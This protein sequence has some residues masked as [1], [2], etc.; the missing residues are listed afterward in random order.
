[1]S[2]RGAKRKPVLELR[3]S[4]LDLIEAYGRAEGNVDYRGELTRIR[5]F[6]GRW[7]HLEYWSPRHP[8][9]VDRG[10][11]QPTTYVLIIKFDGAKVLHIGWDGDR[12]NLIT[13]ELGGWE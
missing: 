11:R 8:T 13:Y 12:L 4:A 2:D 1:M 10:E 3:D 6:K 9:G 7:L 5:S